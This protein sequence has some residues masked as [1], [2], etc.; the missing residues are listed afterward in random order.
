MP[1]A[2]TEFIYDQVA[3]FFFSFLLYDYFIPRTRVGRSVFNVHNV[4]N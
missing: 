2:N 4:V 1:K 3:L